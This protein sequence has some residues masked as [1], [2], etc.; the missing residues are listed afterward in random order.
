MDAE[1]QKKIEA[2]L[3]GVKE[4]ETLRSVAEL[5]LVRRVRYSPSANTFEVFTDIDNPRTSCFVC[6][7]V[8]ATIQ[9]SIERELHKAFEQQFPG[10]QVT[11]S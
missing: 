11:F 2:I 6:G 1:M 7:L 9:R 4:P 10:C 8:T 3:A 5:G